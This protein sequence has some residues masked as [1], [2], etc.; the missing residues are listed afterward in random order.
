MDRRFPMRARTLLLV[1][2]AVVGTACTAA[3]PQPTAADATRAGARW[4]GTTVTDLSHG[5]ELYVATCAG[6]HALKSPLAVAPGRWSAA[7]AEM[8]QK[9]GVKLRDDEATLLVR[10][11]W[12]ASSGMRG[13]ATG[14]EAA[15]R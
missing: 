4:P 8:R 11:L 2:T 6:C 12:T 3:L 15:G 9:R 14:A 1:A 13:E 7:V 10:Y 5:R